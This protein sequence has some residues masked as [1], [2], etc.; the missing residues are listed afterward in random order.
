MSVS[1]RS[2]L[3]VSL[4][5]MLTPLVFSNWQRAR[6]AF[7]SLLIDCVTKCDYIFMSVIVAIGQQAQTATDGILT[8]F[9]AYVFALFEM[10]I[11]CLEAEYI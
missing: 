3:T 5:C 1:V 4:L 2:E 11:R 9:I 6:A 7:W 10:P 8:V